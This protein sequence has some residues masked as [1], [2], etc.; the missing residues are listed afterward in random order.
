MIDSHVFNALHSEQSL[1]NRWQ[2]IRHFSDSQHHSIMVPHR[3]N[4]MFVLTAPGATGRYF[5]SGRQGYKTWDPPRYGGAQLPAAGEKRPT[6]CLWVKV[7][8]KVAE[9]GKEMS[10]SELPA[11]TL[12][13]PPQSLTREYLNKNMHI[14]RIWSEHTY[15][16]AGS[17]SSKVISKILQ[18]HKV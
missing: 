5:R 4:N 9:K 16:F 6:I 15:I 13:L 2:D 1:G 17:C 7:M 14:C 8:E 3:S 18:T 10:P 11:P 12:T